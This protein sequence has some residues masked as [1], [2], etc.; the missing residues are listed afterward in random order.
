MR[1]MNVEVQ[2]MFD[3]GQ[4]AKDAAANT[5]KAWLAKF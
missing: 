1:N 4:S 3:G 2:K 5:Q